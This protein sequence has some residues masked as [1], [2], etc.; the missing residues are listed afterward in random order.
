MSRFLYRL[1]NSIKTLKISI[2]KDVIAPQIQKSHDIFGIHSK[3]IP[4]F[5]DLWVSGYFRLV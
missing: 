1:L 5:W 2:Y 4:I 3:K